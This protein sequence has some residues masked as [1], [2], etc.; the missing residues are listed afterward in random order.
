[1]PK[2]ETCEG[3]ERVDIASSREKKEDD[4]SRSRVC[5]NICIYE[6][7]ERERDRKVIP[8]ANRLVRRLGRKKEK[9]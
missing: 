7:R 6:E 9:N 8:L 5:S 4:Y 2:K 1:M 3:E